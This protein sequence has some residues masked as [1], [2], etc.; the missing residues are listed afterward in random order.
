MSAIAAAR[1]RGRRAA[2][3]AEEDAR[4]GR[5]ALRLAAV[6]VAL[7]PLLRPGGPA[8]TAPVDLIEGL[9]IAATLLWAGARGH[10]F[11]LALGIPMALFMA[12]GALGAIRGPVPGSGAIALT[13]DALL[14]VWAW[15]VINV[16]RTPGR[17]RALLHVWAYAAVAWALLLFAGL[18]AGIPA[19]TGIA[20]R[21]GTRTALTLIDPNVAASYWFVSIMIV[22]A[23]QRPRRRLHRLAAYALLTCALVSTGSSSGLVSLAV[24]VAL[25]ALLGIGRRVGGAPA[26]TVAAAVAL[27]ALVT[28]QAV[29]FRHLQER[30]SAS[31]WSFVRNGIGRGEQS[32]GQRSTLLGESVTL[33]DTGGPLGQGPVSTKPRLAAESAPFVKEA[34]DDYFAALTERGALGALGLFLLLGSLG[35][36]AAIAG[37]ARGRDGVLARPNA[38]VGALA[39]TLV[40][41]ALLE[42][43]HVRHV[44]TLFALVAALHVWGREW[45][46]RDPS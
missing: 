41:A 20:S 28:F 29:D 26:V 23:V 38:I 4:S 46:A 24:G 8:N 22:W 19:L 7:L 13:Q 31:R 14:V 30:A 9:T 3:R 32:V 17:L 18:G 45:R 10:R 6:A 2:A 39:G 15:A 11:R 1:P 40:A 12:G 42:V 43:L 44:W 34:H 21:N 33:L 25:A 27:A 5:G 36:R 37:G 16:A 35:L